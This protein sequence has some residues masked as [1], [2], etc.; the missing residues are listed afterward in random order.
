W[1]LNLLCAFL[2]AVALAVASFQ[3]IQTVAL[4]RIRGKLESRLLPAFWDRL[5][6]LPVRFFAQYDA[7]DLAIRALGPVHLIDVL[8][9]TTMASMMVSVFALVNVAALFALNW[10]LGLVAAALMVVFLIATAAALR[11]LWRCQRGISKV[12]GEI[13]G[14]LFLLLGG[15][16]RLRVAG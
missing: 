11:P 15:I 6:S 9:S 3:A 13:A 1:Q 5:L 12:R 8:A 7:G 16:S 2:V 4:A 10:R 14:L